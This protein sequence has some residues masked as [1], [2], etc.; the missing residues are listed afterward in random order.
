M[1]AYVPKF[2]ITQ[3][4]D[5]RFLVDV[6]GALPSGKSFR[7]RVLPKV[8]TRKQAEAYAGLL[9]KAALDG[10]LEVRRNSP[11]LKVFFERWIRDHCE[12]NRH[13]TSGIQSNKE[14][15]AKHLKRYDDVPLHAIDDALIADLKARCNE[16]GLKPKTTNNVLTVLGSMLKCAVRW[17]VIPE[18]PS[19]TL[20][21]INKA[22]M[23][24]LPAEQYERLVAGARAVGPRA[25]AVVLLAGDGGLRAGEILSLEWK[26]VDL[27]RRIIA[28]Q[29][30]EVR[31]VVDDTKG[32][33]GRGIPVT[34]SLGETLAAI[35]RTNGRVIH[36][37]SSK[38]G[39][40]RQTLNQLVR[41][42]EARAGLPITGKLHILRHTYASLLVGAGA[43]IYQLQ[44]ALGH[45]D[46]A[47]T[48]GYAKL[49]P[50][51]LRALSD[52]IDHR[53]GTQRAALPDRSQGIESVD[54]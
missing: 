39:V 3:Q 15:Y 17:R 53:R 7:R 28:V 12:A 25:L 40:D 34:G 41:A 18:A 47:T 13:K 21:K 8:G 35:K 16:A 1:S 33:A 9:W 38:G 2:R 6:R 52:L 37:G 48:Q 23:P 46:T 22:R 31:G 51:A 43:S 27:E 19:V 10:E 5:G 11:R 50:M 29:R 54:K 32:R 44:E 36:G 14:I 4:E 30:A 49:D 24:F 45:K 42:A 20:L 26:D